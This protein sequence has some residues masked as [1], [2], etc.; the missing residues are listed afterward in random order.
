MTIKHI[1]ALP[2]IATLSMGTALASAPQDD[3]QRDADQTISDTVPLSYVEEDAHATSS[4]SDEEGDSTSYRSSSRSSRSA[5]FA[6]EEV[7]VEVPVASGVPLV[8]AAEVAEE[9]PAARTEAVATENSLNGWQNL[10]GEQRQKW[11]E[12]RGRI[13]EYQEDAQFSLTADEQVQKAENLGPV[14]FTVDPTMEEQALNMSAIRALL[15]EDQEEDLRDA[16]KRSETM[17]SGDPNAVSAESRDEAASAE[18]NV[19]NANNNNN[20][21]NE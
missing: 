19:D 18:T 1:Y 4:G 7:P 11:I 17:T 15:L 20:N 16:L 9:V 2:I 13:G 10:T 6:S 3:P 12:W 14:T 5:S 21:E 8:D